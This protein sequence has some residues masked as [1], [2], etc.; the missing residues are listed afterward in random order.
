MA[1]ADP[2]TLT[3]T[4]VVLEPLSHAHVEDLKEASAAGELYKTWY[5]PIAA[6]E[7]M[8]AEIDR[9]LDLQRAGSMLPFTVIE[10]VSGRAVGMTTYMNIDATNRRV[11][12]G[13]TWY[14][15][16]VQRTGLN[17]EAK[18]LMLTHAFETLACIAVE[19]RTSWMN[20]Q[21]RTAIA[22]L[23]AKQD[24]VLRH[25]MWS[26]DGTLRDTVVF[27]VIACEWPAVRSNLM[28]LIDRSPPC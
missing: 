19:F 18:L 1:F 21:S 2:V 6:P 20:R 4:R 16:R 7:R 9:R 11:E 27:S 10:P 15:R 13:S 3:G 25:H 22:R 8:A 23:G 17:T 28:H 5:T 26:P 12:I 14:A 24:G